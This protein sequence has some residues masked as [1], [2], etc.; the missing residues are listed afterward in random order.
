MFDLAN[1]LTGPQ[2]VGYTAMAVSLSAYTMRNDAWMKAG[3]G[4]GLVLWALHYALLSAWTASVTCL[5]IA[6]R[7]LLVT[8][9]SLTGPRRHIAAVGYGI[10]FTVVLWLT[11]KDLA[12]WLPWL[13]ALNATYAY[14]YLAGVRLRGQVMVSTG[15]WL[16]N[17]AVLGSLGGVVMNVVT[18]G[19]SGWTIWRMCRD[20]T[21]TT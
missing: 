8:L 17:A 4:G 21:H 16:L 11:W 14:F 13:S 3:V 12:S 19:L 18:L 2:L 6:S 1:L 5:L 10:V 20:S 15:F 9:T 7:Q